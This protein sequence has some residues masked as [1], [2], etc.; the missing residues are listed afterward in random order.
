M[1]FNN[2]IRSCDTLVGLGSVSSD[3]TVIFGKNSDRPDDEAQNL[4]YIPRLQHTNDE[5]VKCTYISIPQIKETYEILICQPSWIWGG[6]MGVNEY[7]VCIGNEAVW[8]IEEYSHSGLLGMD[9]LRLGL[10]RG[11]D[12]KSSMEIIIDLLEK[13]GQGGA[14]SEDGEMNYHNSFLIADPKEAWVLETAGKWWVAEKV[15]DGFRA[16]SNSLSIRGKGTLMREGIIDYVISRNIINDDN[17]FDF[18]QNFSQGYIPDEPS[19]YSRD[20]R[21]IQLLKQN[22]G[23]LNEKLMMTI[24]R[25][26]VAGVCMHGGFTSTASQVSKIYDDGSTI[27]WF[28]NASNPCLNFYKPYIFPHNGFYTI[29]SG[30]YTKIN[31]NWNWAVF[32]KF[33]IKIARLNREKKEMYLKEID[34]IEN[35]LIKEMNQIKQ[36]FSKDNQKFTT[37]AYNITKKS[38]DIMEQLY[39]SY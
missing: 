28:T 18:A 16:I 30:P 6:E 31:P 17:E 24:L 13:F 27:N 3:G 1:K 39:K 25:D 11:K 19:P 37:S 9:L 2:K 4:V 12:A 33:K 5:I 34:Q 35:N 32:E 10:E 15:E 36:K 29:D 20:G 21:C 23:K 26:H 14:C 22:K 8:T 38:W 7:G